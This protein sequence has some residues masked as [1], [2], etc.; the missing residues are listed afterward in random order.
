MSHGMQRS[1][2]H[3][4]TAETK[5]AV[6]ARCTDA[7]DQSSSYVCET[8]Q[9]R[10]QGE[11][12][13]SRGAHTPVSGSLRTTARRRGLGPLQHLC[14]ALRA[15]N[16]LLQRHDDLRK[17]RSRPAIAAPARCHQRL[18]VAGPFAAEQRPLAVAARI[19]E[20][21]VGSHPAERLLVRQKVVEQ[22]GEGEDLRL[23]VVRLREG[24]LGRH[25]PERARHARE[26][27]PLVVILSPLPD[28]EQPKIGEHHAPVGENADVVWLDVAME[29]P[30]S[31]QELVVAMPQRPRELQ[32]DRE[33]AGER[34]LARLPLV[35]KHARRGGQ[36]R[37]QRLRKH[38]EAA[39]GRPIL[40][41][42]VRDH[43][44]N[45]RVLEPR[46]D[47]DFSLKICQPYRLSAGR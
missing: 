21:R 25:V 19:S 10:R 4:L 6:G 31:G 45:V 23:V 36:E 35:R 47:G 14:Q 42:A 13:D 16:R 37:T 24:D 12:P 7:L 1:E 43:A 41:G 3:D 15:A 20:E 30:V 46:E 8:V 32:P 18:Y 39:K 11:C 44:N 33:P 38:L 5:I 27:A 28:L 17:L 40:P 26:V 29:E 9:R 34:P 22:R 2:H